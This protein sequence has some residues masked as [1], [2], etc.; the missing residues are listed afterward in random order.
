MLTVKC[1]Q[2]STEWLDAR[3][4]AITASMF[5]EC[6]KVV[7]GL[8]EQQQ[9]F[10]GLVKSGE[11]KSE[12]MVKSGYKAMPT[13]KLIERAIQGERVGDWSDKAKQY[14]FRLAV[15]RISGER[16]EEDKF[17]TFEMRRGRALEPEARL[18]HEEKSGVLVEQTG[19]VLTDDSM[20]GASADGLIDGDGMSEYKCFISPSS[21]MPILLENNIDDHKDQVQGGLWITGRNWADFVLYCPALKSIGK[22]LTIFHVKRDDDYIEALE[23]DLWKFNALVER[24][25]QQLTG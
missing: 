1:E 22:D 19:F 24:Y 16:L 18:A 25:K 8:N 5:S 20:F 10:V 9:K 4:G 15:E 23:S 13:S 3:T 14:A 12:A 7:G 21:L 17:E 6:R 11:E 2:G